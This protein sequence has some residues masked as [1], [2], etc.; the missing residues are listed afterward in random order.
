MATKQEPKKETKTTKKATTKK[1]VKE[2]VKLNE[3]VASGVQITPELMAQMFAMFQQMQNQ[4]AT[5]VEE[6]KVENKVVDKNKKY[7]KSMLIDIENEMVTI[8][9]VIRNVVFLSPKTQ[10]KYNWLEKGDV[11]SMPIKEILNMENN[12]KRFLH[13]PWLVIEDER[14]I[15][16]LGLSELY[17]LIEKVEDVD[18]LINLEPKEIRR[19]F[20]KLPIEYRKNFTNQIIIKV[21]TRELKDLEVIDTLSDILNV[22]LNKKY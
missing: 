22:D 13:T 3:Q 17:E 18:T 1:T 20:D 12:S 2:E 15:Q 19:V 9:S 21:A 5:Q 10:I 11:E 14:V 6:K 16:A 4:Q 8:R 7:T